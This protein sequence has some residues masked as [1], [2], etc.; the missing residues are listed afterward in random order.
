MRL[1][2]SGK[3]SEVL[4]F[5]AGPEKGSYGLVVS[6]CMLDIEAQGIDE[7]AQS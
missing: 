2:S 5:V 1:T 7:I 3:Y 4:P 6:I